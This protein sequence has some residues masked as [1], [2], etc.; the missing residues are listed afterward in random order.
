MTVNKEDM[1]EEEEIEIGV[2]TDVKHVTHIGWD[3]CV[4]TNIFL[5]GPISDLSLPPASQETE[6]L[7]NRLADL[8]FISNYDVNPN[9]IRRN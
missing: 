6:T 4:A 7:S 9:I 2:P 8:F 1:E 3:S 5:G